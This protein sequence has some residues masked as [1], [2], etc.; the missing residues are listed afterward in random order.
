[1]SR[2]RLYLE[3]MPTGKKLEEMKQLMLRVHR[4]SGHAGMSSL[5]QMLKAKGVPPWAL[6][7]A[8]HLKCPECVEASQPRP[9]PPAS[10]GEEAKLFEFLGTDVF[11]FEEPIKD[12]EEAVKEKKEVRKHKLMLWR[13]RASGLTM[14]DH[15]ASFEKG[16]WEPT[17]QDVIKSFAVWISLFPAPKWVVADSARYYTSQEFQDFLNRSGVGLAIAPAEAHWLMGNEESAIGM[18]KRTVERLMKEGS[19]LPVQVLFRLASAAMNN[20]IG[21]SGF[22]AYQWV[23]GHGG[24]VLDDEQL[25][26]GIPPQKAFGGLVKARE[27]AQLAFEKER[28]SSKFSKL[29]NAVGRPVNHKYQSGQL[30]MLWRQRVR[31]GK[32]KGQWTGPVRLILQE[33]STMWLASGATL[34][35]AKQNQIRPVTR[36]ESLAATLEGTSIYKTPVSVTSLMRSFQGRYYLDVAGDVPSERQQ[37]E[38]LTPATVLV[39]AQSSGFTDTWSLQHQGASRVLIRHH[40]LPRL[41]LF[42]PSK[43]ATCPVAMDELKGPRTTII[44]PIAGGE[45]VVY[46]DEYTDVKTLQDRWTGESRFELTDSIERPAKV[47]RSMPKSTR[48][49]KADDAETAEKE[50]EKT[51]TSSSTTL[52]KS[53]H[54]IGPDAV[55]GIPKRIQGSSGSNQCQVPECVLPGGHEGHTVTMK[56]SLER[57]FFMIHMMDEQPMQMEKRVL[58]QA[59]L[60]LRVPRQVQTTRR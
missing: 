4:A 7:L 45:Q 13:D 59:A 2:K 37:V 29:A 40:V 35:R 12:A 50:D 43:A 32:V 58:H 21:P 57:S 5:V 55:D 56:M 15:L 19:G 1:M 18:A 17:S 8:Q 33:G 41:A 46:K 16:A 27:K 11:E 60:A 36:H 47:R 34:I 22:S 30:V 10:V 6:E 20:H 26:Q 54:E 38:D 42:D 52:Q 28:A 44:K 25:L 23:F 24:G 3:K 39:D 51:L 49:R 14:I 9:P 53:L 48:K 31:P